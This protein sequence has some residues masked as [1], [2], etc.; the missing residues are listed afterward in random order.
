MNALLKTV[1]SLTLALSLLTVPPGAR[2]AEESTPPDGESNG[3]ALTENSPSADESGTATTESSPATTENDASTAEND[4]STA[5]SGASASE[6]ASPKGIDSNPPTTPFSDIPLGAYYAEAASWAAEQGI[7]LGTSATTFSPEMTTSR[8][9]TMTFFWRWAGQARFRDTGA[10]FTDVPESY[11][12]YPSIMWAVGRNV[13][14]GRTETVFAPYDLCTYGNVLTFLWRFLGS[15]EPAEMGELASRYPGKYYQ[16][17]IAWAEEQ[18]MLVNLADRFSPEDP[19]PR[20]D[21]VLFLYLCRPVSVEE[22][23]AGYHKTPLFDAEGNP[24]SIAMENV[25]SAELVTF[26]AWNDG[27]R[28]DGKGHHTI[29]SDEQAKTL[30]WV[31][32]AKTNLTLGGIMGAPLTNVTAELVFN[33]RTGT[34][35]QEGFTQG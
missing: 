8:G 22:C 21:T 27:N 28:E 29:L 7:T 2:A 26:G 18:G 20:S 11:H 35:M 1:L 15:P 6:T 14:K 23:L 10:R 31:V 30:I 17:A 9:Q 12:F 4:T 34:L 19:C 13:T 32:T 25:T 33:A 16:S 24:G 3:H 5:E